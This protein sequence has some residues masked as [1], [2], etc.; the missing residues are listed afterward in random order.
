[1]YISEISTTVPEGAEFIPMKAEIYDNKMLQVI[2]K[3]KDMFIK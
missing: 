3:I 1:M 2:N